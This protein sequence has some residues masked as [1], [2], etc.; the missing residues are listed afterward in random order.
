MKLYIVSTPIG[1]LKDITLRALEV[2]KDVDFILCEDTRVSS[3][4]LNHFE[5]KKELVSLNAV[6]ES[7]K[8]D[9][10]ISRLKSNQTGALISDAGTPL[11]SDPGVR[12]VSACIENE[13][14]IIFE[15]T[16]SFMKFLAR[17]K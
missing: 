6:N 5:I 3:N 14:E 11:I 9:L 17:L 1:N 2:L 7:N 10:I 12:L 4:L 16:S 8:I 15:M 13:I